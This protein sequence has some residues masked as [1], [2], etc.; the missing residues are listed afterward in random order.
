MPDFG[1]G[2]TRE[3]KIHHS[4]AAV[5]GTA[6]Q[7]LQ[8]SLTVRGGR[9]LFTF[10]CAHRSIASADQFPG[11]PKANYDWKLWKTIVAP[12]KTDFTADVFPTDV[13]N[14]GMS[15]LGATEYELL[16]ELHDAAATN[17]QTVQD[18]VYK[19]QFP[20]DSYIEDLTITW[21]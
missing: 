19:S 16:I 20:E 6:G 7:Y 11:H 13:F 8:Y 9:P 14:V 4:D 17:L 18:I 3:K 21:S 2:G 5:N 12:T 1:K 15:F 10:S